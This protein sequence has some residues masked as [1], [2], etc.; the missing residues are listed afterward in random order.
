[1]DTWLLVL[2]IALLLT[3]FLLPLFP[4]EPIKQEEFLEV[5]SHTEWKAGRNILKEFNTLK[6]T[7]V[8][9]NRFYRMMRNLTEDG[10]IE[11]RENLD[12]FGRRR[13]FKKVEGHT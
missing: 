11:A 12:E 6:G 4:G 8:S 1:M 3:F 7:N 13:E 5:L 10:L 2:G 9:Y